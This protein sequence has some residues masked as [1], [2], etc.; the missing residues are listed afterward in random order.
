MNSIPIRYYDGVRNVAHTAELSYDGE[1]IAIHYQQQVAY[2]TLNEV[3]YIAGV[4]RVLPALE[5]PNDARVEFL[6]AE[7]PDW[8]PLKHQKML[9]HVQ[10]FEQSWKW[11]GIGFVVVALVVAGVLKFG[12]P[13]AAYHVAHTLPESTLQKAGDHAESLIKEKIMS[14][15]KL[16]AQRQQEISALYYQ[17]LN[18]KNPAKLLFLKGNIFGANALAIPNNTIVL[19]D[20]LVALAKNDGE[21]IA[22]LAHEQGHLN[23]KH[24]LQQALRAVGVGVLLMVITG[25]SDDLLSN[26]PIMLVSAQYSQTFELE[27]DRHAIMELKRL[28]MSPKHLADMLGRLHESHGV[29]DDNGEQSNNWFGSHPVLQERVK[30]VEQFK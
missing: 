3:E 18:P 19:T 13:F 14:P 20:E 11:V 1:H 28:N 10:H 30:Q 29:R 25:E 12:I 4:G 16:S 17:K 9:N 2:Y 27:A 8:L 24:S 15:S 7:L 21:L 5:L 23:E 22:V 26:L 6:S